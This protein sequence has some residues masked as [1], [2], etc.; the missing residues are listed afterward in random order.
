MKILKFLQIAFIAI[1]P[2]FAQAQCATIDQISN[3]DEIEE[4][5][6]LYRNHLRNDNIEKALNYWTKV[7]TH[8]PALNGR[9]N[10]VYSDG[11]ALYTLRFNNTRKRKEKK[12]YAEFVFRLYE[13]EKIC[14]P[15]REIEP[16]ASE[17]LNYK[18]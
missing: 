16:I 2:I 11:R 18:F 17:I 12:Y 4:A 15:G 10:Y 3:R 8:A 1:S 5:C 14:F 7:Y 6:V 9:Y 13:Q